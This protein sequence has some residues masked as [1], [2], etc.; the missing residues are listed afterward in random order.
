LCCPGAIP[1]AEQCSWR[2]IA[3]AP[4]AS[5]MDPDGVKA[6]CVDMLAQAWADLEHPERRVAAER[7]LSGWVAP[8]PVEVAAELCGICPDALR[9]R[10]RS[11][12]G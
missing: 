1:R 3:P 9:S 11:K 7:W 6:M 2:G 10:M 4:N 12:L 8:L 5:L